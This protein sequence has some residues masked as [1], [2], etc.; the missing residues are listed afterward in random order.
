MKSFIAGTVIGIFC[1]VS[2]SLVYLL[3]TTGEFE[4]PNNN[5]NKSVPLQTKGTMD[6]ICELQVD[7][8]AQL[9]LGITNHE[10]PRV[11][12]AKIDFDKRSGWYQ[13]KITIS[14]NRAGHLEFDEKN[15]TVSRPAM[16]RRFNRLIRNEQFVINRRSGE[17]LQSLTMEDGKVVNLIRG[18][19]AKVIK[20]PL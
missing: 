12:I 6:L 13:G 7:L 18:T 8:D 11:N 1:V 5:S 10:Q 3:I 2:F 9:E 14:E 16:I 15:L 17:F 4:I 20:A 19:C